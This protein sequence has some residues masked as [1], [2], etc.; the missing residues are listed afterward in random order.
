MI[1]HSFVV[2][3]FSHTYWQNKLIN[4]FSLF[5]S[6]ILMSHSIENFPCSAWS[7]IFCPIGC[8]LRMRNMQGQ[9]WAQLKADCCVTLA[10]SCVGHINHVRASRKRTLLFSSLLFSSLPLPFPRSLSKQSLIICPNRMNWTSYPRTDR[11]CT[12]N[13][14][15][16]NFIQVPKVIVFGLHNRHNKYKK[17]KCTAY[18]VAHEN[19]HNEF[20]NTLQ[21]NYLDCIPKKLLSV[22]Q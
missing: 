11:R 3:I 7:M 14:V 13:E 19:V 9:R 15:S 18:R 22:Y 20:A 6:L 2:A 1:Y 12:G 10:G 16:A 5:H 17:V 8:T 4:W 21:I